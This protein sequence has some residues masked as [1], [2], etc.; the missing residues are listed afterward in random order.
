[1]G[2][3]KEEYK[4]SITEAVIKVVDIKE[5][6]ED[7]KML[8]SVTSGLQTDYTRALNFKDYLKGEFLFNADMGQ[9]GRFIHYTGKVWKT[10]KQSGMLVNKA[11]AYSEM[12][13][14]LAPSDEIQSKLL[15]A[16]IKAFQNDSSMRGIL[17][18][19][20]PMIQ[21]EQ[22]QFDTD[23]KLLNL[24]NCTIDLNTQKAREHSK[25]DMITKLA[26]DCVYDE[27]ADMTLMKSVIDSCFENN[28]DDIKAFETML[29]GALL[30][31]LSIMPIW[32]GSGDNGKS[33]I[34]KV[35]TATLGLSKNGGYIATPSVKLFLKSKM[36]NA[37]EAATPGLYLMRNAKLAFTSE[38]PVGSTWDDSLIKKIAT[39]EHDSFRQL[40][41]ESIQDRYTCT[42]INDTN[43]LP[44]I[45][46]SDHGMTKRLK[47]YKFPHTFVEGI[48]MD[49]TLE[50]R[51]K[52]NKPGVIKYLLYCVEQFINNDRKPFYSEN[53]IK[54]SEYYKETNDTIQDFIDEY[55]VLD[56]SSQTKKADIN[57]AYGK[58]CDYN[59]YQRY[60]AEWLREELSKKGI[61]CIKNSTWYYVGVKIK[62]KY[63]IISDSNKY[64]W[65]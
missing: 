61:R 5:A 52:D 21:V 30:G 17:K 31:E 10:D 33:L 8:D 22:T 26:A 50:E 47:V 18:I 39:H 49:T 19:L 42:L 32:Y 55:L 40:N 25:N 43:N 11:L 34:I 46:A 16:T 14:R 35:I 45:K 65:E 57:K 7:K 28:K 41:Q 58:W 23:S 48:D 36:E 63:D 62:T 27:K 60:S 13:S 56:E 38:A 59:S 12:L 53:V 15:L 3:Y 9:S 29:G 2:S 54:N 37:S 6:R 51:L 1:M 64:P 44:H 4:S 24:E 20:R